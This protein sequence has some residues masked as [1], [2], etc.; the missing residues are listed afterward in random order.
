MS[1][2]ASTIEI[3]GSPGTKLL[4]HVCCAPCSGAIVEYLV[5]KGSRPVLFFS[6]S[7]IYPSEEYALRRREALRYADEFA[8]EVVDD[9]YDHGE[10]LEYIRG[11]EKEPE[12]GPRCLK[13]FRFRL[14]RAARYAHDNGFGLLTTTLASSRWKS[15]EQVDAA[16]ED[17]CR[18]YPD[19]RWW[20]QNWRKCGLQDRRGEIIREQGFYNQQY[21]GCEFSLQS[22]RLRESLKEE[23]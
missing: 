2:K 8:L 14:E 17:A 3:P 5:G 1:K 6:N 10:W 21:C 12:R 4:L 22:L 9:L 23:M 19:V 11:L 15:L 16:G 7:N 20:G 18:Q 13:C